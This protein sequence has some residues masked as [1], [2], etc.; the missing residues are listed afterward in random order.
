MS[1]RSEPQYLRTARRGV[2]ACEH[3]RTAGYCDPCWRAALDRGLSPAE[4]ALLD[5]EAKFFASPTTRMPKMPEPKALKAIKPLDVARVV[6]E[7]QR[8]Y[9]IEEDRRAR[10]EQYI[11]ATYAPGWKVAH[12]NGNAMLLVRD[13]KAL[14]PNPEVAKLGLKHGDP[15]GTFT[16]DHWLAYQRV[17]LAITDL[18]YGNDKVKFYF[19]TKGL[20]LSADATAIWN[21]GTATREACYWPGQ[22]H[23]HEAIFPDQNLWPLR[24][25]TLT[26][27]PGHEGRPWKFADDEVALVL[28]EYRR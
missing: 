21:G 9:P 22:G 7:S 8:L 4:W 15:I 5:A 16:P 18:S 23:P 1:Y 24:G 2:T 28:M 25:R 14:T 26:V 20:V 11:G 19:T 6:S 13:A 27:T 10:L 3:S 17:R 12:T